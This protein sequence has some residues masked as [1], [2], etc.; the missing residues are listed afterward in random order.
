MLACYLRDRVQPFDVP[1]ATKAAEVAAAR[2]RAGRPVEVRD[3]QIAGIALARR[4][5]LATRNIR[6]FE[7]FGVRLVDPWDTGPGERS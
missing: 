4:A 2:R 5:T 6:H 1:A 3:I 7:G